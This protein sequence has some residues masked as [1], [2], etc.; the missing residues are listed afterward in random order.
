MESLACTD[1]QVFTDIYLRCI[2]C[3]YMY[4]QMYTQEVFDVTIYV[5]IE[6]YV[7]CTWYTVVYLRCMWCTDEY[8][9]CV[10]LSNMCTH[11]CISSR[12]FKDVYVFTD[13]YVPIGIVF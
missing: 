10:W 9:I 5:S 13:V 11:R 1:E 7:R 2:W 8:V 6:F 4:P 3:F 12:A